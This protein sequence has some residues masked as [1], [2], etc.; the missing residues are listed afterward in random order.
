MCSFPIGRE[1]AQTALQG[2]STV[3]AWQTHHALAQYRQSRTQHKEQ[4]PSQ[5]TGSLFQ[6]VMRQMGSKGKGVN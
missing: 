3:A 1:S 5:L 6:G 2:R 4:S